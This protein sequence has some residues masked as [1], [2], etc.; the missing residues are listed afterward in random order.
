MAHIK[1][2]NGNALVDWKTGDPE[3]DRKFLFKAYR[4]FLNELKNYLIMTEDFGALSIFN[5][6]KVSELDVDD[7]PRISIDYPEDFPEHLK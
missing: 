6:W 7:F 2:E 1:D 5:K 4:A 3:G